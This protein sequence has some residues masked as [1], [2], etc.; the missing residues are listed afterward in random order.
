VVEVREDRSRPQPGV[1]QV[2]QCG[3]ER[4]QPRLVRGGGHA[5]VLGVSLLHQHLAGVGGGRR[6]RCGGRTTPTPTL[7]C[8]R[9]SCRGCKTP[10]MSPAERSTGHRRVPRGAPVAR[11]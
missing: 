4:I 7:S 10:C 9:S 11:A 3:Q 5:V 1:R 8:W 2:L 6:H